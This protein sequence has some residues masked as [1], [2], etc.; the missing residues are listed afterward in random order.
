MQVAAGLDTKG[1]AEASKSGTEVKSKM[2]TNLKKGQE[3][4]GT[5]SQPI[6]TGGNG[7]TLT[8]VATGPPRLPP[9]PVNTGRGKTPS[10]YS[11]VKGVPCACRLCAEA[12]SGEEG[13]FEKPN[14]IEVP[15]KRPRN[16]LNKRKYD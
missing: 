9:F 1:R 7:G 4:L 3:Y 10:E 13:V 2:A 16:S 15:M 6:G 5:E 11:G 14:R 8:P 12:M